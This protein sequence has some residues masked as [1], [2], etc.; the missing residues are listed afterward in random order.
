[1][2]RWVVASVVIS[3]PAIAQPRVDMQRCVLDAAALKKAVDA[4]LATIK[5]ER[6]S[7]VGD[8]A[9]VVECPDAVTAHL[10]VEPAFGDGP[11]ARTVDLGEVPG[12][13]RLRLVALAVVELTEAAAM[14]VLATPATSQ[15]A[16]PP[17]TPRTSAIDPTPLRD[18]QPAF[19]E[20]TRVDAPV[21]NT[22][23]TSR[24]ALG[25]RR[26]R[27][28]MIAPRVGVR[29]YASRPVLMADVGVD[30]VIGPFAVGG[31][32]AGGQI[33]DEL[34][35]VRPILAT[36]AAGVTLGC[37]R[38][39]RVEICASG[40]GRAGVAIAQSSTAMPGIIA[41]SAVAPYLELA[42]QLELAWRRPQVPAVF[43]FAETGWASGL[44]A[45][46]DGRD[47]VHLDGPLVTA[48]AG[49]RW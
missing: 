25:D 10:R 7:A 35:T 30:V 9:I 3:A 31:G 13:L 49:L 46:S 22:A 43:A 39:Q 20:P 21:A 36:A 2:W 5:P 1:V 17:A 29:V 33:S 19:V 27:T 42:G 34:G 6:S 32:V 8:R 47:V 41:D 28:S 23:I 45:L 18:P 14:I 15:P 12:E 48:G 37:L 16:P 11:L 38:P 24:S 4:E 44:V 26:R 40:R